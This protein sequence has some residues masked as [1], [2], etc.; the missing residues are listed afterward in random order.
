M[1]RMTRKEDSYVWVGASLGDVGVKSWARS[2]VCLPL[3]RTVTL[4]PRVRLCSLLGHERRGSRP[5]FASGERVSLVADAPSARCAL[6]PLLPMVPSQSRVS[7]YREIL[8]SAPPSAATPSVDGLVDLPASG[9]AQHS[10]DDLPAPVNRASRIHS[11]GG[12]SPFPGGG[13]DESFADVV[14]AVA[15]GRLWGSPS[16]EPN[17]PEGSPARGRTR[18]SGSLGG[19]GGSAPL[20]PPPKVGKSS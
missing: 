4:V 7:Y 9:A 15:S 3:G 5:H 11:W 12:G 20:F 19:A 6:P 14:S 8:P 18:N 1:P 17:S 16:S 13:N 2:L 10:G